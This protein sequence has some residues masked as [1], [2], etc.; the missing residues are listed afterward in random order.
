MNRMVPT[1]ITT[2]TPSKSNAVNI[3]FCKYRI[4]HKSQCRKHY[5]LVTDLLGATVLLHGFGLRRRPVLIGPTDIYGVVAPETTVAS[6]HIGAQDAADYVA[7][8]RDVVD[9]GQRAGDENVSLAG[10]GELGG[11]WVLLG[12]NA[13]EVSHI[14][15]IRS[16]YR[17]GRAS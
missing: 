14:A 1:K 11:L 5:L 4:T 17:D 15:I 8:M 6:K 13:G 16:G 7:E 12:C 2:K 9:I 3:I 10:D